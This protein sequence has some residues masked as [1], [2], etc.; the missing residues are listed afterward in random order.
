MIRVLGL[1]GALDP[2]KHKMNQ[3]MIQRNESNSVSASDTKLSSD[4]T[5]P[6][7]TFIVFFLCLT[8]ILLSDKENCSKLIEK[9]LLCLY[10]VEV[11]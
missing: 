3:G 4:S 10:N 9:F 6:G 11:K 1:L 7:D 8:H 2:H 5:Q